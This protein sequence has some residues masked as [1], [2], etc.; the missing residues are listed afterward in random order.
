MTRK[1]CRVVVT[2]AAALSPLGHDWPT[3]QAAILATLARLRVA[4]RR[5]AG[6][7]VYG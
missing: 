2:G 4:S 1:D 7:H 5:S 3:V 6:A